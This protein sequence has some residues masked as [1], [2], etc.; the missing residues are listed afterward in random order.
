VSAVLYAQSLN[1]KLLQCFYA[2]TVG[3]ASK[4][5]HQSISTRH[6]QTLSKP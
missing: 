3:S 1:L 4:I 6:Y 5:L 2:Q